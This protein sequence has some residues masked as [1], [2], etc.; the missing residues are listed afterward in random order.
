[1]EEVLKLIGTNRQTM[2]DW[3]KQYATHS[4]TKGLKYRVIENA[5]SLFELSETQIEDLANKAGFSL[6]HKTVEIKN[7]NEHVRELGAFTHQLN[8]LIAGSGRQLSEL[9]NKAFMSDRL[10][11]HMKKGQCLRKETILSLLIVL[12]Q[13][14]DNI[15]S[16]LKKAGYFLSHSLVY[17]VVI[18]WVLKH[19]VCLLDG[20]NRLL[21]VNYVLEDLNL[22][23][24]R[25]RLKNSF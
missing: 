24:V 2:H 11:R 20:A 13:E 15:Q 4:T 19:E 3:G 21:K 18:M 17:D 10:L 25:T 1:M 12:G 22:P 14:L 6:S 7:V 8:D 9:T 5:A 23:L 16:V